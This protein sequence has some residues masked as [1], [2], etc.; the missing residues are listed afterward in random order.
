MHPAGQRCPDAPRPAWTRADGT[1]YR[2]PSGERRFRKIRAQILRDTPLCRCGRLA[3]EVDH[4]WPV[5]YGG[6]RYEVWNLQALCKGCHIRKTRR[7]RDGARR[8]VE[9]VTPYT[10]VAG[11]PL[12]GKTTH[13][14]E[15]S[16]P[17]DL[18]LDLDELARAVLVGT[19]TT[20]GPARDAVHPYIVEM[21]DAALD[22]LA[23]PSDVRH[24]WVIT[25]AP[26]RPDRARFRGAEL[27][28]LDTPLDVC[29]ARRRTTRRPAVTDQ[30]IRAWWAAYEP[31]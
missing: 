2:G 6:P 20:A 3:T 31:D 7:D 9:S 24:A 30:W 4:R 25:G 11:P 12:A 29:L 15:H 16:E 5:E 22:R 14:L 1:A 19:K 26:R 27:V 13:V 10:V 18:V 28:V 8:R 23:R 21:R 17:G